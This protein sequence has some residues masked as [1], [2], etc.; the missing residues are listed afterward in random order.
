MRLARVPRAALPRRDRVPGE[1]HDRRQL[2]NDNSLAA[3]HHDQGALGV[4][5]VGGWYR[6]RRAAA[7]F[8]GARL[9]HVR[10]RPQTNQL[11]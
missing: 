2:G 3:Q 11:R 1:R 6:H 4:D 8:H 7:L 9:C 5:Y 10:S